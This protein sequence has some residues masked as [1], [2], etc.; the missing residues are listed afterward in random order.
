M[1]IY[2]FVDLI[3]V[4]F[5]EDDSE[6]VG[7]EEN[8]VMRVRLMKTRERGHAALCRVLLSHSRN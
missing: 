8:S 2:T 7:R 4:S 5:D 3:L 6:I 1:N